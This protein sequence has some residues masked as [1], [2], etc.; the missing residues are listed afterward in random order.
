[1]LVFTA[2]SL[3]LKQN[4][5]INFRQQEQGGNKQLEQRHGPRIR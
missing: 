1:M 4:E 5:K 3:A 2:N